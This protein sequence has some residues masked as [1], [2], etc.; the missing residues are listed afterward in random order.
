[1]L[2]TLARKLDPDTDA[3]DLLKQDHRKVESLFADF[4]NADKRQKLRLA[5]EI[6]SELEVHAKIEES[7]FYP[8]AKKDARE[9]R[10]LV[11][12][13]IVEHEGIKRLIKQIP[14]LTTADEL[15]ESRM[16]VLKE[17]VQHHVKEEE[18]KM[19]PEIAESDLDLK[20]LG[21][22][23]QKAK[24]RFQNAPASKAA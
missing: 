7:L 10:D 16:K 14:T 21:D 5:R 17:Y 20:D 3:I 24:R 11:N 19:F 1:M 8:A 4:E 9:A 23:L 2:K 6:C 12:E 15:F 13:G 18:G 22:K